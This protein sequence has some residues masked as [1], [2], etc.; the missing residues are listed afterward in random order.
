MPY[1]LEYFEPAP[2]K[3]LLGMPEDFE[4]FLASLAAVQDYVYQQ[5]RQEELGAKSQEWSV[6][7]WLPDHEF[8]KP[9]FP[10]E[11]NFVEDWNPRRGEYDL[12]YRFF[13]TVA[14]GLAARSDKHAAQA[15]GVL[16]GSDP[17]SLPD[18]SRVAAAGKAYQENV[19]VAVLPIEQQ[20]DI[21]EMLRKNKPELSVY[22]AN[23]HGIFSADDVAMMASTRMVVGKRS[24]ATYVASC[25]RDWVVELYPDD[26]HKKWLSKWTN[27]NYRM[28]YGRSFKA[29]QIW[30][31]MEMLW[32][33]GLV[34]RE[35]LNPISGFKTPTEQPRYIVENVDAP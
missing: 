34:G 5:H 32:Q 21:V 19:D 12:A 18:L 27:K 16:V 28:L 15:F 33:A 24:D 1:K 31:T 2:E 4:M 11:V 8:M 13:P 25:F 14:Y 29:E 10:P 9:A 22:V 30:K 26:R 35:D 20:H 3:I 6:D 17:G 7:V 23:G